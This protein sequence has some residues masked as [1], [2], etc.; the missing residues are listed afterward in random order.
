MDALEEIIIADL[1]EREKSD[2][3]LII[4]LQTVID[5]LTAEL[6]GKCQRCKLLK[7]VE[8]KEVRQ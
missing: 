4:K 6:V 3:A 1:E 2:F 5:D 7:Q 8:G